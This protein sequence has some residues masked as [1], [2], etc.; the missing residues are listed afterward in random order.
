MSRRGL[1][2]SRSMRRVTAS[3]IASM[4]FMST[5]PRP[6]TM[7][8]R[9]SAANGSKVQSAGS[10]GTTSRCPCSSSASALGSEPSIR[11]TTL[12]RPGSDSKIWG[13]S[14][15]SA[16]CSATYSAA[17]RSGLTGFDVS[18][19]MRSRRKPTTSP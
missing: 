3:I 9:T 17:G 14:P 13:S 5:A 16:S 19:R 6:H 15:A 18:I 7:P 4:S 12:A 8:S 1:R 2:P 11:A 10:A